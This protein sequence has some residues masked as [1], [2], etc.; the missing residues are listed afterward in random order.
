M[1]VNGTGIADFGRPPFETYGRKTVSHDQLFKTLL[2]RFFGDFVRIVLPEMAPRLRLGSPRFL[3]KELFTDTVGGR[4][5]TLDLVA[6]VKTIEAGSELLLIHVEIE[7]RARPRRMDRRMWRY[8]MQL[9]LRYGRPVVPI[10]L[11]LRGGPPDITERTVEER[12]AGHL[13]A[14]FR[15]L[16]FG[17]ERS[18]AAHYLE[19][20][21]TLAPALASLMRHDGLSAAQHKLA[22]LRP[23]ARAPLDEAA[24]FLLVNCIETYIQLDRADREEYER[25]LAEEPTKEVSEMEMTWADTLEAKGEAKGRELGLAEGRV[26]GMR[27]V[28][29]GLLERRFGALPSGSRRRLAAIDSTD[30]LSRLAGRVLDARSLEDLGL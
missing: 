12:F 25:L 13:L 9:R 17:L 6:Q 11:Y 28:I 10:V 24:R 22:C 27:A 23:V 7:A 5:R 2:R 30:E 16:V 20:D 26:R 15:Y 3:D 18:E 4:Q 1:W 29:E 8:A 21:E 19:R 14:S